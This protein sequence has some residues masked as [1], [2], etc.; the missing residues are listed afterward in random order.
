MLSRL[1]ILQINLNK[2]AKAHLELYNKVLRKD[3]DFVL[4][5]EPYVTAM[6]NIRTPTGYIPV[7][8]VDRYKD[9]AST[10]RAVIWVS[11]DLGTNSW[12]IL[13]VPGTNDITVIQL[14]GIYGR[15][16][17]I[18][19]Y[20]DCTNARTLRLVREYVHTNRAE[21]LSRADD[22]LILAGDFNRHHPMWDE[23]SDDRLFTPRALEDAGKLIE[24]LADLNLKMALP[25]S[26]AAFFFRLVSCFVYTESVFHSN[27]T[28]LESPGG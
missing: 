27:F 1:R 17:I 12:K 6:G 16:T 13:N 28:F 23:E 24:L 9:G 21:I 10:T 8:P 11:S 3:W 7:I 25:N 22:H 14:A 26:D 4:V 18:N 2:S 5:Q 15:L 19:I 20:N